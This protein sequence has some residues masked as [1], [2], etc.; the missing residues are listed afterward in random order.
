MKRTS[1]DSHLEI[2]TWF[3][4]NFFKVCRG[5]KTQPDKIIIS[6]KNQFG[7][8]S[9]ETKFIFQNSTSPQLES[10]LFRLIFYSHAHKWKEKNKIT[11][12][13][14]LNLKFM[15]KL[16]NISVKIK[17]IKITEICCVVLQKEKKISKLI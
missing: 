7:K 14:Y 15:I 13:L 1:L 5:I 2:F 4:C 9:I 12:L 10:V 3:K 17:K 11:I 6:P 8:N 16:R